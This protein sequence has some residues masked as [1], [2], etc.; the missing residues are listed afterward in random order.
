MSAVED[1]RELV[2]VYGTL[3]SEAADAVRMVDSDWIE[4]G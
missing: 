3:R 1:G 4:S 2:F